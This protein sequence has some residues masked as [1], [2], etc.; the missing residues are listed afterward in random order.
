MTSIDYNEIFE[1]FLGNI[2]EYEFNNLSLSESYALM[3]EYLQKAVASS[4]V[5]HI[6]S[7]ITLDDEIH[8]LQYE[9]DYVVDEESDNRFVITVLAK[10]MVYEW[11]HPQVRSVNLTQQFFGGK[12]QQF[13]AQQS[14]LNQLRSLEE[15]TMLEVRRM[16]RDRG[17]ISNT[18][19]DGGL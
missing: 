3:T 16:I 12:E 17:Y 9:M 13:F 6:F 2:T 10:Q 15:D 11:I 19:L 1:S 7:S 4:Y 8:Q 14:H 5:R 18:Y